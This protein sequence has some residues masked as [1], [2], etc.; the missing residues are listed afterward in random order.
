MARWL[1]RR[2]C[3]FSR[4]S[5]GRGDG[6]QGSAR[7]CD[8]GGVV[9]VLARFLEWRRGAAGEASRVDKIPARNWG[10]PCALRKGKRSRGGGRR[11]TGYRIEGGEG[12]GIKGLNY[13][14]SING[15]STAASSEFASRCPGD[16]LLR[17]LGLKE[18][19]RLGSEGGTRL[20]RSRLERIEG[21]WGG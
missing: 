17:D 4:G 2:W 5:G 14:R 21:E 20:G 8:S 3:G 9:D 15:G 10:S 12:L 1:W 16:Y 11:R 19:G 7:W 6:V 18:K 13:T